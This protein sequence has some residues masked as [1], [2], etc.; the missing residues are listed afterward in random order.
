MTAPWIRAARPMSSVRGRPERQ[1]NETRR[2][3]QR[4][5]PTRLNRVDLKLRNLH[6]RHA[7]ASLPGPRLRILAAGPARS[8]CYSAQ[9]TNATNL[10]REPRST[11]GGSGWL[12]R[13][14]TDGARDV[15]TLPHQPTLGLRIS[16]ALVRMKSHDP[17]K[18]TNTQSVI[19]RPLGTPAA[20][21][22]EVVA[23]PSRSVR[24]GLLARVA[25]WLTVAHA[26]T[27]AASARSRR[28]AWRHGPG[29]AW[30]LAGGARGLDR[31][32]YWRWCVSPSV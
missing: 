8:S 16:R 15:L 20:K 1:R 31:R 18:P 9:V 10:S 21:V 13:R 19:D 2:A 7:S 29:V 14:P 23:V 6:V 30:S 17:K 3:T 26:S 25:R 4:A 11:R 22:A 27:P 32:S 24:A 28:R 12:G 5:G